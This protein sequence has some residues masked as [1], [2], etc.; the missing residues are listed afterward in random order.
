MTGPRRPA[1][2]GAALALML[3][4]PL[5]VG[6]AGPAAPTARASE[7]PAHPL[8]VAQPATAPAEVLLAVEI[9]AGGQVKYELGEDGLLYA[10]RLMAMAVAY[11][12]NYGALPSTLGG[13][14]DP[15]DG[16]VLTRMPVMPGALIKVRPVG[17]LR[18]RD[19][20]ED[21]EKIVAVPAD[22]VDPTYT[23]V[24]GLDD[25]PALERQRIEAFFRVYKDLPEG[26]NRIELQG[27]GDAAEARRLVVEA[28]ARF[29]EAGDD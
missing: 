21:D 17:V 18:M 10:D 5:T 22:D 15:L 23:A 7:R 2:L 24:R 3:L 11:P 1:G 25:L 19:G 8:R 29:A 9:P 20:G 4:V 14:G 26:T 27:W 13:D 16:L 12:A 6:L 28:M